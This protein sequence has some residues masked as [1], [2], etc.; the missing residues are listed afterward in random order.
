MS[1]KRTPFVVGILGSP[2]T[3]GNVALLLDAALKGAAAAGADTEKFVLDQMNIRPCTGCGSCSKTGECVIRD[4]MDQIYA[5]YEKADEIILAT[6]VYFGGVTAQAKA[7]F[8]RTQP[9]W[10]RK[11]LL[12]KPISLDGKRRDMLLLSTMGSGKAEMLDGMRKEV[13]YYID[14]MDGEVTELIFPKVDESGEIAEHWTALSQA[15]EAGARL[16]R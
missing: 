9:L 2:R 14:T 7:M 12:D 6:P 8:D 4:D 3:T 15:E 1:E 5:A 11:Y 13:H 16:V 10:A